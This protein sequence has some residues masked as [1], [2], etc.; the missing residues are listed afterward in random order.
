MT[1]NAIIMMII[2]LGI[3]I[4]GFVVMLARLLKQSKVQEVEQEME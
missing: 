1:L 2:L 3:F 4:G